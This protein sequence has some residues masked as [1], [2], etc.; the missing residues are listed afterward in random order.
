MYH[1][2]DYLKAERGGKLAM[3]VLTNKEEKVS[4]LIVSL[5]HLLTCRSQILQTHFL[6]HVVLLLCFISVVRPTTRG[7]PLHG[8]GQLSQCDDGV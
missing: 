8:A 4:H 5:V 3:P 7:L 6:Q 1:T 2:G